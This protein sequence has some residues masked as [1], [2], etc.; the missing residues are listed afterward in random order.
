LLGI[1]SGSASERRG[2]AA[3]GGTAYWYRRARKPVCRSS[4][5]EEW[6]AIAITLLKAHGD[7]R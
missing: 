1:A 6:E 7:A 3:D 5:D 4:L 2:N